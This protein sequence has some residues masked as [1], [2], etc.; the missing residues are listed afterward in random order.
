[1]HTDLVVK[2]WITSL[3]FASCLLSMPDS[4]F[5][6]NSYKSYL[7]R[8][9]AHEVVLEEQPEKLK[10][11]HN[12]TKVIRLW[13]LSI[14]K[15]STKD[16]RLTAQRG[17]TKA[18]ERLAHWSGTS[19]DREEAKRQQ[20]ALTQLLKNTERSKPKLTQ[21]ASAPSN[22]KIAIEKSKKSKNTE[23]S[24]QSPK[25][26]LPS[27]KLEVIEEE[28]HVLLNVQHKLAVKRHVIPERDSRGPRVYFDVSPL[29]ASLGALKTA[30]IEHAD[31]LKLRVGQFDADTVRFVFDVE[32]GKPI[33]AVLD[34]RKNESSRF[35]ISR[36]RKPIVS[37]RMVQQKALEKLV[38]NLQLADK[39]K[40]QA[41]AK[42]KAKKKAK[43]IVKEIIKTKGLNS[44]TIKAIAPRRTSDL[45]NVRKIVIDPGHGGKDHGASCSKHRREKDINLAIAKQLGKKLQREMGVKIVYTRTK[46]VFVSLRRRVEIANAAGADLFISVHANANEN[47]KVKGVETYYLNTTTDQY[48]LR[49]ARRE[50]T[51]G[52]KQLPVRGAV[53]KVG[54]SVEND[55]TMP[56]G[57]VGRD[58]SLLLADLAMKSVTEESRKLAGYIQSSIV[59]GLRSKYKNVRDLG[60]KRSL[61]YVL[62]GV[63]M[64]SVLIENGFMSN[65][66]EAGRLADPK[67]QA[68]LSSAIARGVQRF[69]LDRRQLAQ[70]SQ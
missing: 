35:V 15:A 45:M 14:S 39:K 16:Q 64:P 13:G 23:K 62:L 10:F 32:K 20:S 53:P 58:M 67:Y 50:N 47:K 40:T 30:M 2:L 41:P 4:A 8:A 56:A 18:W 66:M 11:R 26:L 19:R 27:L 36:L 44:T 31:V 69:V 63:R 60:V 51:S 37:E 43:A 57:K 38:E 61:F 34:F 12:S 17:L 28:A 7:E 33:P 25:F 6:E 55:A 46:D 5:A 21:K 68:Q 24:L 42:S 48:A 54:S 1:M 59:T 9:L 29:V 3:T 52:P 49:L 65:S 22:A 70:N